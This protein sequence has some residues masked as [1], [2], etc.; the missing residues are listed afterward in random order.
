M[1]RNV[2]N[3]TVNVRLECLKPAERWTQPTGEEV[4]VVLKLAGLSGAEAARK[5]GLGEK[6]GRT[7]RRWT[8]DEVKVPYAVW[9]LLCAFAGLGRIWES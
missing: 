2:S 4:K 9:A 8:G 7:V 1:E 5:L 3:H 6:G